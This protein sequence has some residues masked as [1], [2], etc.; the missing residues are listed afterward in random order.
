VAFVSLCKVWSNKSSVKI[1]SPFDGVVKELF[2]KEGEIMEVGARLCLIKVNKEIVCGS[3]PTPV[4]S[5]TYPHQWRL[6][7]YCC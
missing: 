6:N 4:K 2:V 5:T 1:I 7:Q 3:E